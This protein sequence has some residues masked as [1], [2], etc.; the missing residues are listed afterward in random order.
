MTRLLVFL[1]ATIGGSIGWWL[2]SYVGTMTAFIVSIV[3]TAA[4]VYLSR[5]FA[6]SWS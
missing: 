3:G 2:G 4:G 6:D 1:G 5:R